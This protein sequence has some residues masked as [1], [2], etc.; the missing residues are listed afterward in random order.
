MFLLSERRKKASDIIDSI[1]KLHRGFS[2]NG[3]LDYNFA[4]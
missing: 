4:L 3:L 1:N 2:P